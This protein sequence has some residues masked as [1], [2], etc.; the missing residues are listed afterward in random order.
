MNHRVVVTGMGA[1]TP[2]GNNVNDFFNHV[3]E[4]KSGIDFIKAFDTEDF[5]VKVA[6]E[7]KNFD[8]KEYMDAKEARRMD[9]FSQF[10]LAAAKEAMEDSKLD[11]EKINHD[12][13]GV[14][15]VLELVELRISK[16]KQKNYLKKVQSELAH[17]LF[18]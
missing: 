3:K 7:V 4:G 18:Q 15:L 12:R 11:L 16:K 1:I 5:S 13:F 10:A 17:Y 9:R 6:A 8:P 14:M 2:I